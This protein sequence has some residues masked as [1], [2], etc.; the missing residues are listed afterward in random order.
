MA[1]LTVTPTHLPWNHSLHS[2][3]W[4][5]SLPSSF[6]RHKQYTF[7]GP[8]NDSSYTKRGPVG[9]DTPSVCRCS[10]LIYDCLLSDPVMVWR[11][12]V[13]RSLPRGTQFLA[14]PLDARSVQVVF[15]ESPGIL[16]QIILALEPQ[17]GRAQ[18]G[19]CHLMSLGGLFPEVCKVFVNLYPRRWISYR[20]QEVGGLVNLP[21]QHQPVRCIPCAAISEARPLSAGGTRPICSG[22][23]P[24][25]I[26]PLALW[27]GYI[28][29]LGH[30]LM[31]YT[32]WSEPCGSPASHRAP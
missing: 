25:S 21:S 12:L 19:S 1:C 24:H 29:P 20:V 2:L 15:L 18:S 26:G 6:L 8:P 30:W 9:H 10:P 27:S 16:A 32:A 22:F 7:S 11:Q 4:T 5:M 28:A 23:F 14:F 3:H 17:L 13:S 31:A